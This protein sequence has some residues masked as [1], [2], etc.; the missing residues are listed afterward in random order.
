MSSGEIQD[1]VTEN[2]LTVSQMLA[3]YVAEQAK[4]CTGKYGYS[5]I[6]AV[7]GATYPHEA[8]V[9][10]NM[11]PKNYFLVPGYG[12]QGGGAEDVLPCFHP[13][14]LG[15][16]VN[17]SRGVLYTHMTNEELQTCTKEQYLESVRCAVVRMQREIYGVLT[18]KYMHLVY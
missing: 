18:G 11:M 13:D 10:R 2:G 3:K 9:L 5:S 14:G 4:H 6:G 17:S 7:V 16:V 12:A 1:V 8:E 15:A